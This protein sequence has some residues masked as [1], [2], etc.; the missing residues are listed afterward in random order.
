MY[1]VYARG[2]TRMSAVSGH[3]I[4]V[5]RSLSATV[6]VHGVTCES[7]ISQLHDATGVGVRGRKEPLTF[8]NYISLQQ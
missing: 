7:D 8:T 1:N 2:R 5:L 6:H 4:V 3:I